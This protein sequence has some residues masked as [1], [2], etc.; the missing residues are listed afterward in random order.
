[1]EF[2]AVLLGIEALKKVVSIPNGMEFYRSFRFDYRANRACFNSQRDGI[3]REAIPADD[4]SQSEF[5]FPTGWNS[6]KHITKQQ[7]ISIRV[8]IPNGMEFYENLQRRVL[9]PAKPFQ[10]PT[11]W[12]STWT[13]LALWASS[14]KVSIPNGMEF[15][16]AALASISASIAC[17]NSQRDGILP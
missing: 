9:R 7:A 10:F 6:T 12:N 1:M 11:G 4:F 5:Q 2:Y 17:F 8:S 13:A 15:Y 3:L 14:L 16:A